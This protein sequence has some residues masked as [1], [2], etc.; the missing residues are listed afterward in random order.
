MP[1]GEVYGGSVTIG[2]AVRENEGE[3]AANHINSTLEQI[4]EYLARQ[5]AQLDP[6]NA[7]LP[8]LLLPLVKARRD[9]RNS[10]QDLL[11]KF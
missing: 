11:D 9:R 6:F 1:R 5:K 10:A 3:A 8:G 2:M 4:E 7:A